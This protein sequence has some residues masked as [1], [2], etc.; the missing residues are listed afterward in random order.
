MQLKANVIDENAGYT[1]FRYVNKINK[2][3]KHFLDSLMISIGNT[4]W[5]IQKKRVCH[6]FDVEIKDIQIDTQCLNHMPK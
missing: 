6:L 4:Y 5:K 3:C 2:T 1:I